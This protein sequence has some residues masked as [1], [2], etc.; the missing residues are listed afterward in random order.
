MSRIALFDLDRTL[1]D[2]NSGRLWMQLEL[3]AGNIGVGVAVWASWWL[4]RY[5][6]GL[7]GG[8]DDVYATAVRGLQ[9]MSEAEL[10]SRTKDWFTERVQH[11]LRPGGRVH[12]EAHR[13]AGDTLVLAT[14]SSA[15]AAAAATAAF[16][17]DAWISTRF[18]VED[19]LFTGAIASSALGPHKADRASEWSESRGLSLAQAVFYTDSMT[20]HALLERVGEPVAVNPDRALRREAL[21]RGWPVVD[22]GRS[23]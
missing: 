8:L 9:G 18:E 3:E 2:C 13:A 14:S 15:Y 12:L 4:L 17:L 11:R 5:H 19:G 22:W 21:R 6:F 7:G 1:L 10:A 20:D 16:G 23:T